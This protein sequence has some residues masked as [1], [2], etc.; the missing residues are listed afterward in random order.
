[1]VSTKTQCVRINETTTQARSSRIVRYRSNGNTYNCARVS[2][3]RR[4]NDDRDANHGSKYRLQT[5]KARMQCYY[6]LSKNNDGA[7]A[8]AS[9]S[10]VVEPAYLIHTPGDCTGFVESAAN[11]SE[12]Q[13]SKKSIGQERQ[14]MQAS[15]CRAG[16]EAVC[17]YGCCSRSTYFS[18]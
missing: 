6:W 14:H 16:T 5:D 1:M 17:D 15:K 9:A 11:L 10:F 13:N 8:A 18:C 2:H 7:S 3:G 4:K 12:Q